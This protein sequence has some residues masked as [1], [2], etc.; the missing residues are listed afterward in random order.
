MLWQINYE[1]LKK[2]KKVKKKIELSFLYITFE[3]GAFLSS[4]W[5]IYTLF[6]RT[7]KQEKKKNESEIFFFNYSMQFPGQHNKRLVL[8]EFICPYN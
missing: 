3:N 5:I 1:T 6:T 4:K 7:A 8:F 2:R